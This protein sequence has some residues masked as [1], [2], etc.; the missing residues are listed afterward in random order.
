M[1][2]S[3]AAGLAVLGC[4]AFGLVG[5]TLA[6]GGS[7]GYELVG[8]FPDAANLVRGSRVRIDGL[9]VGAV[10][11][12]STRDGLAHVRFSVDG[13]HTP[14]PDGTQL[15]VDYQALLG[16]RVVTVLPGP[17]DNPKLN[18]G[19]M[20]RGGA[21]RVDLDMV[22]RELDPEVRQALQADLDGLRTLLEPRADQARATI[23]SS[24]PAVAALGE[25]LA[26]VGNDGPALRD[27]VVRA[28]DMVGLLLERR[29]E[30]SG[31]IDGLTGSLDQLA[32]E[33]AALGASIGQLPET[34]AQAQ[35]TLERVPDAVAKTQPMLDALTPAIAQLP[36]IAA[37]LRPLLADLRPLVADL[38][39]SIASLSTVLD[40]APPL[41]GDLKALLPE[42]DAATAASLSAL[43]FLRPYTPELVGFLSNWGS[44]GASYD[45]NGHYARIHV[46][47]GAESLNRLPFQIP[48]VNSTNIQ[49]APGALEGEPWTDAAGSEMH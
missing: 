43:D 2:R 10:R 48:G 38:R 46:S 39:P 42:V 30:V 3:R 12:I 20:I 34:L 40:D 7:D 25:V 13:E 6:R 44:A 28:R 24:G 1:L 21:S 33:R 17:A 18:S 35:G 5:L 9:D 14:L 15:R 4:L 16:E 29:D 26:A 41:L 22:L 27:L 23:T 19:A 8:V 37:D 49:R 45:A 11:G 47:A 32:A 31:T 36:G